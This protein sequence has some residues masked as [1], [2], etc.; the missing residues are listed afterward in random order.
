NV[1][2]TSSRVPY[3]TRFRS[4][5]ELP[6]RPDAV[7]NQRGV[8]DGGNDHRAIGRRFLAQLQVRIFA[9][10]GGARRVVELGPEFV[11]IQLGGLL[12]L[13]RKSTSLNSSHQI[14]SS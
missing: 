5:Q 10:A 4:R 11:V 7:A 1:T 2:H 3:T 14:N 6:A 9:S 8:I 13:D 12:R